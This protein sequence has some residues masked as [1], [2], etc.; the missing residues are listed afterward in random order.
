MKILV[1]G[2]KPFLGADTNPSEGL[3]L[4]LSQSF[5]AVEALVLPV[6][7]GRSFE[8]LQAH[9]AGKNYGFI[10]LLGQAAGRMKIS[11]EKI[12][13]NW[14]QT[15]HP[16][17]AGRFFET[18]EINAGEK[19][20]LM[21]SFEID[22]IYSL[23]KAENLPVEISFSAGTFV[24]NELYY[25]T[26]SEVKNTKAVFIHVPLVRDMEMAQQYAILDRIISELLLE[27]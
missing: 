15:E 11:F 27:R 17:E 5:S 21:S 13:L 6:E 26:L 9:L 14:L 22:R 10:I 7:F 12:A 19:L 23:L 24:C 1:T 20:A 2:F 25:R 3:A 16:D 8:V 4:R 18:G